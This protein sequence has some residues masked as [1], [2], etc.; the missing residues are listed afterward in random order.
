MFSVV[1][2]LGLILAVCHFSSRIG[3]AGEIS[4]LRQIAP[5]LTQRCL[6]CHG[7]LKADGDLRLQQSHQNASCASEP[8]LFG[9]TNQ[10]RRGIFK[11]IDQADLIFQSDELLKIAEKPGIDIGGLMNV[12]NRHSELQGIPQ[13]EDPLRVRNRELALNL[14]PCRLLVGSP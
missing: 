1:F 4:F 2:R 11:P 13:I 8:V 5:I 12:L 9:A 10:F 6:G 7:P 14:F 3:T